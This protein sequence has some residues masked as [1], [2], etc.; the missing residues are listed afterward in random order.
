[1]N[2]VDIKPR[3]FRVIEFGGYITDATL[4][5]TRRVLED[6]QSAELWAEQSYPLAQQYLSH[7]V[8]QRRLP[9]LLADGLGDAHD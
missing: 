4:Q 5:Q 8:L 7:M 1:M 9:T 6:H 3:G 2:E